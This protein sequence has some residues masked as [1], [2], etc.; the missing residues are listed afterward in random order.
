MSSTE[1][2]MI[3]LCSYVQQVH[4]IL[5]YICGDKGLQSHKVHLTLFWKAVATAE[6][7]AEMFWGGSV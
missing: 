4:H 5:Y 1:K 2:D 3:Y 6:L 7:L